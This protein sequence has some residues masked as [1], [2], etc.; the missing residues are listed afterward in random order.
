MVVMGWG[1]IKMGEEDAYRKETSALVEALSFA[2]LLTVHLP[3]SGLQFTW[4]ESRFCCQF[5]PA[6]LFPGCPNP[7]GLFLWELPM[8]SLRGSVL[9]P[10][11][12]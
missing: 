10:C 5:S 7:L 12:L 1:P 9:R 3:S 6:S 2:F 4:P 11:P 8:S